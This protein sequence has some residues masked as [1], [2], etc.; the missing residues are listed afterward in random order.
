MNKMRIRSRR[1]ICIVIQACIVLHNFA[2]SIND[3]IEGIEDV[4]LDGY[5]SEEED[6][7]YEDENIPNNAGPRDAFAYR[8]FN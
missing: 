6:S 8:H 4:D 5:S 7:D 1:K 2:I 3:R